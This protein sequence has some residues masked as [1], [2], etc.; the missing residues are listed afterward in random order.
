M[1]FLRTLRPRIVTTTLLKIIFTYN[2]KTVDD[3]SSAR[4]S[5]VKKKKILCFR[6]VFGETSH[7]IVRIIFPEANPGTL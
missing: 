3:E 6:K 4:G 1:H 5:F 7:I 2:E